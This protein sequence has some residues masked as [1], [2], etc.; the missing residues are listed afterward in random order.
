MV[1][2]RALLVGGSSLTVGT[3]GVTVAQNA[4]RETETGVVYNK[5]VNV[6]DSQGQERP[7]NFTALRLVY[8]N[9]PN[10]VHGSILDEFKQAYKKPATLR[11]DEALH[12]ALTERFDE[13]SYRLAFENNGDLPDHFT[14][15]DFDRISL[16]DSVEVVTSDWIG[17]SDTAQVASVTAQD[18]PIDSTSVFVFTKDDVE[19]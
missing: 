12:N 16:G 3:L 10:T 8:A 6:T 15:S 17:S 7:I 2:R 1:S 13:V 11:V 4:F 9:G 14:R 5:Y 18:I 19:N